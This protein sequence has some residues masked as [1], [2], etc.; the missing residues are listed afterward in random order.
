MSSAVPQKL[1]AQVLKLHF[2]SS[3]YSLEVVSIH[4]NFGEAHSRV[5]EC[6]RRGI[7]VIIGQVPYVGE[8][9]AR[10][11][12]SNTALTISSRVKQS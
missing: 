7:H 12:H 6:D 2:N 3:G 5:I 10:V 11:V 8:G 9:D 1:P 4:L